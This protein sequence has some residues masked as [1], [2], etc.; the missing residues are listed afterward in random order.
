MK[1]IFTSVFT[2]IFCMLGI[3]APAA[4]PADQVAILY[5]SADPDS[6]ILAESYAKARAIPAANIIA[7]PLSQAEEISRDEFTTSLLTPLCATFDKQQWW[8]MGKADDGTV[9]ATSSRI[10]VLVTMRGVPLKIARKA[11]TP[12]APNQAPKGPFD[13]ANEASVD[14]ELALLSVRNLP[15][16][17]PARNPFFENKTG[18]MQANMPYLLLVGRIDGPDLATCQRMIQD[19]V[20]TE[21]TGLWGRAYY[22]L[23]EFH[24]DGD[25][26]IRAASLT[27][28]DYG[29]PTEVHPWKETY[30]LN[31]PM[32]DAALY[33]GWYEWTACGPFT[34]GGSLRKGSVAVHLHS[35]SASTVRSSSANWCGPLLARGA[36]ATIGNVYEPY[37]H[38]THH[39][40]AFQKALLTGSSLVEAAYSS[41]PALS[42]QAIVLGDPLYRPFLHLD[43]TGEKN[44]QDRSYRAL[45]VART[46][47]DLSDSKYLSEIERI[48][49][50]KKNPIFLETLGLIYLSRKAH[51]L[52]S[53]YFKEAKQ[54]YTEPADRLHCDLHLIG[55][56]RSAGRKNEVLRALS[57]ATTEYAGIPELETVRTLV[58][59]ID[60]PPPPPAQLPAPPKK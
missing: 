51:S 41:I 53:L 35:F 21:K 31:Y 42:W 9:L 57:A 24:P 16:D 22:D 27:A 40:D 15:I 39:L 44:P 49:R 38:L 7:L 11:G 1:T 48:G 6:K 19:A 12:S 37:L 60:P 4:I 30:P 59:I 34:R 10:K 2:A 43:A 8:T 33:F 45:R 18:I 14:A 13:G 25:K 17:G 20:E 52:A 32:R 23:S 26:W 55:M 28:L 5:N 56:D 58:N 50:E 54:L 46:I 3:A 29:I 47:H 36:A